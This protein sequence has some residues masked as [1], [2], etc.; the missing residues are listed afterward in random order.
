MKKGR[1][2]DIYH[3]QRSAAVAEARAGGAVANRAR[4]DHGRTGDPLA[5]GRRPAG[6]ARPGE[7]AHRWHAFR[8]GLARP[9]AR[10]L[11]ESLGRRRSVDARHRERGRGRARSRGRDLGRARSRRR[12]LGR[13][14][15]RS[16]DRGGGRRSRTFLPSTR[17][18]D[19]RD[20]QQTASH[21][22]RPHFAMTGGATF[23][24]SGG[25][26]TFRVAGVCAASVT[27]SAPLA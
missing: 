4:L 22:R 1:L 16:R 18:E 14:L 17:N 15:G 27:T 6:G 19:H 23:W 20:E 9:G 24:T 13:G 11:D 10:P 3:H 26:A 8:V 7:T 2:R 21:D 12:G 5:P 25:A